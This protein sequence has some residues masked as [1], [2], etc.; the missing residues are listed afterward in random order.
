MALPDASTL[1]ALTGVVGIWFVGFG[2][3]VERRYD[4]IG[5]GSLGVFAAALGLDFLLTSVV[6][7]VV[8][9]Y[10]VSSGAA[11]ASLSVPRGVEF[12]LLATT[13]LSG[14][15]LVGAV[16]SWFWFVLVY[17]TRIDRSERIAVLAIGAVVFLV[18]SVNGL[19]G[20]LSV[21]DY[22]QL[23]A[24]LESEVHAFVGLIEIL[25]T[26]VAIGAGVEQLHR[27]SRRQHAFPRGAVVGL[28]VP[29]LAAYLTRY[30]YQFGLVVGFRAIGGLRLAS[31]LAGFVGLW[32]AVGRYGVFERLPASRTVGRETA[33]ETAE[34]AIAVLNDDE[35]VVDLNPAAEA[36]FGADAAAVIGE[37]AASVLPEATLQGAT[38]Y[39]FPNDDLVV[40]ARATATTD[41]RGREIGR[42]IVYT[43]IT[44]ERRRGQRIEVLNR[45]LRHN[46]RNDANAA[47][48]YVGMAAEGGPEAERYAGVAQSKLDDLVDIGAK[49]REVERMLAS[50]PLGEPVALAPLVRGAVA[51]AREEHDGFNASVSVPEGVTTRVNPALLDPVV[52]ELVGNAAEHGTDRQRPG[53]VEP[54][55]IEVRFAER[56]NALV[57]ADD[58]PGIPEREVEVFETGNETPLQHGSGLGLWLVKWGVSRFGGDVRFDVDE[59]GSSV[60]VVLPDEAVERGPADGAEES[61]PGEGREEK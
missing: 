12:F 52:A 15:L 1:A 46:L 49:A 32:V 53:E 38:T 61:D 41:D 18:A 26:G 34:T 16:L 20:A 14:L 30:V 50:D 33:F 10:G 3:G 2:V 11:L 54:V 44:D 21:F 24:V 4:D 22:V 51:D 31:A 35:R 13:P 28:T 40:E 48:G 25:I 58:G 56:A 6:V 57:V 43:D 45:V 19:I 39:E 9:T 55:E 37:P 8:D 17:T 29:I 7:I 36:L 27:T 23:P 59:G 5:S 60:A 42:T 47:S